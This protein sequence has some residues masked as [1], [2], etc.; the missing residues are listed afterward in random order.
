MAPDANDHGFDRIDGEIQLEVEIEEGA[1][2]TPPAQLTGR[3]AAAA[4]AGRVLGSRFADLQGGE[5]VRIALVR[6]DSALV[7]DAFKAG[8]RLARIDVPDIHPGGE[9]L[10]LDEYAYCGDPTGCVS[11]GSTRAL[12]RRSPMPIAL[13]GRPFA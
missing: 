10:N 5:T 4:K 1:R 6:V 7:L 9:L 8:Q 12:P 11:A 3:V 2:Q 13:L